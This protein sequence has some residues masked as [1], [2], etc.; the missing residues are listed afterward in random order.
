MARCWNALEQDTASTNLAALLRDAKHASF[1][2]VHRW[3]ITSPESY[4]LYTLKRLG[5]TFLTP[6]DCFVDLSAGSHNPRWFKGGKINIAGSCFARNEQVAIITKR[7][8]SALQT[9]SLAELRGH[10][11]G[12][13]RGLAAL[14]LKPGDAIAIFMP[15][16]AE[17]VAIYLGI[18]LAGMAVV[19]IPESVPPEQVATRIKIAN[20]RLVFTQSHIARAG[21]RLPLYE[22]L[23]DPAAQAPQI[24]CLPLFGETALPPLRKGDLAFEVFSRE[25]AAFDAVPCDPQAPTNI[26]FSSGTTGTPKAIVWD[27]CTPMKAAADGHYHQDIRKGDCVCWPTSLG[28]MMGPWLVYSALL[29]S[30]SIALFEGSPGDSGFAAFVEEAKVTM[31]GLVPSIAAGWRQSGSANG[32]DWSALR[33]FS[34][35]GEA[36]N[37]DLYDWLSTLNQP[38]GVKKPI[39]E[40]CGGTEIGGGYVAGNLLKPLDTSTFNGPVLGMDFVVLDEIGMPC[41][42]GKT[43]EVFIKTPSLGLATSILNAN[44]ET[45]YHEG[46]PEGFRRH[47]DLMAVLAGGAWRSNGR[48]GNDMNLNGIKVGSTEIEQA[49]SKVAG[50]IEVAAVGVPPPGGGPDQLVLFAVIEAGADIASLQKKL[51]SALKENLGPFYIIHDVIAVPGLPRTASNKVMHRELRADYAARAR[52]SQ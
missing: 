42:P 41:A 20:A 17:A 49:V 52:S 4:W 40:Y 18:I 12:V 29:N 26:I 16:T 47:G 7:H 23:V 37:P 46:A 28:W 39:I 33:T 5:V 24:V 6:A 21:R 8:T 44:I 2:D 19:S 32:R 25:G 35:S 27:H 1:D 11:Q 30:A 36:S 34:S 38:D 3:S 45:V 31:L 14:G 9:V 22:K 15:M 51:Q 50:V 10:A 48:A 43:G 13:A